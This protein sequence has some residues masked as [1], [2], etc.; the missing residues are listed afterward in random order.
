MKRVFAIPS[1][2]TGRQQIVLDVSEV[3][4]VIEAKSAI[5]LRM[6]N[7][8]DVVL[9]VVTQQQKA[10]AMS[11][12]SGTLFGFGLWDKI[13]TFHRATGRY[14]NP[15]EVCSIDYKGGLIF[16]SLVGGQ[17]IVSTQKP[18]SAYRDMVTAVFGLQV[19]QSLVQYVAPPLVTPSRYKTPEEA[20]GAHRRAGLVPASERL[21]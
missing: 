2:L 19:G 1:S 8:R 11:Y 12:V 10:A 7:G 18:F 9:E 4:E 21:L 14:L 5:S 15:D 3:Q 16:V 17:E 20:A 6:R 13:K